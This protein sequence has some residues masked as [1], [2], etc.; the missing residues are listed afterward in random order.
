[1]TR[2]LLDHHTALLAAS[3][4]GDELDEQDPSLIATARGHVDS[5]TID[6]QQVVNHDRGHQRRLAGA[7]RKQ[8]QRLAFTIEHRTN[9]LALERLQPQTD[10]VGERDRAA[11]SRIYLGSIENSRNPHLSSGIRVRSRDERFPQRVL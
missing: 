11:V 6:R 4:I 5:G 10:R 7:T 2:Q 9:D 8:D 1:M 3:A